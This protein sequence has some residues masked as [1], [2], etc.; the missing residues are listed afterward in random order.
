MQSEHIFNTENV[1]YKMTPV[2]AARAWSA[3]KS[4]M[5]IL[6]NADLAKVDAEK[7]GMTA[8]NA[9]LSNLGSESITELEKI[10]LSHTVVTSVEKPYRLADNFDQHFNK[11][12]ADLIPVLIEGVKYQ[13]GDFFSG[14]L[15]LLK[16][17]ALSQIKI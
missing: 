10:V 14:G 6:E 16:N 9:I 12:R 11:Y 5:K 4:A 1:S 2:N 3:L 17:T 13:F 15:G 7:L 8:I